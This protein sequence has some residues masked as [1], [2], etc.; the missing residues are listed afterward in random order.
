MRSRELPL[1]LGWAKPRR[2]AGID[3]AHAFAPW[4]AGVGFAGA[5]AGASK[6]Q[7]SFHL[8]FRFRASPRMRSMRLPFGSKCPAS[9][10]ETVAWET[11]AIS[12]IAS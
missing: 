2:R 12:A 8:I 10:R 6:N 11:P 3:R 7:A 4:L 5:R 9:H 1:R